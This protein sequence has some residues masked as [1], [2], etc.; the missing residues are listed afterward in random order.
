MSPRLFFAMLASLAVVACE[1]SRMTDLEEYAQGVMAREP[2]PIEPLPE[3]KQIDTFVYAPTKK[4]DPFVLDRK[5]VQA[6]A[7]TVTDGIAPDPLRRKEELEQFPLDSLT[8]R[9]TLK[10]GDAIWA[11]VTTPENTLHH[12][13]VGNYLGK[14]NGQIIRITTE[15]IELTEIV[16]DGGGGWR[17]R[18]A[19]VALTQ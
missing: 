11:L 18:Q 1:S 17:E 15:K 3:I 9:G 8:M 16:S 13:T 2:G 12:A 10:Q 5:S 6:A 7:A 4:R 19:A 14:N